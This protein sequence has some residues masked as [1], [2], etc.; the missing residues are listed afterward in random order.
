MEG[1]STFFGAAGF[2]ASD[3]YGC[4]SALLGVRCFLSGS[5]AL[6]LD[7]H[8]PRVRALELAPAPSAPSRDPFTLS[9]PL[10]VL[11]L[12]IWRCHCLFFVC[13]VTRWTHRSRSPL[14]KFVIALS[15]SAL[16]LELDRRERA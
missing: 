13:L 11:T 4:S 10:P 6:Q 12:W 5:A 8:P 15:T 9:P 2:F 14:L 1:R 3:C 16:E 7:L